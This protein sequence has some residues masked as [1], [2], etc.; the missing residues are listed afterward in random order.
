MTGFTRGSMWPADAA[1]EEEA[2]AAAALNR[3]GTTETKI[4]QFNT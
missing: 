2:V 3:D 1:A 4:A